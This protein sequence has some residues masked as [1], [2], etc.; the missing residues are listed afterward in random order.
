MSVPKKAGQKVGDDVLIAAKF[1][2]ELDC[3]V[4]PPKRAN[5]PGPDLQIIKG[6]TCYNV[7]VKKVYRDKRGSF[8][9]GPVEHSRRNDDFI[10]VTFSGRVIS[11]TTMEQHLKS[12]NPTGNRIFSAEIKILK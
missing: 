3:M 8:Y 11:F 2:R 12:C 6:G 7:E 1:F 9:C 5:A 10:A 4:L